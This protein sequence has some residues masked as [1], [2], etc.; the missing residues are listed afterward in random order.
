M[1]DIDELINKL[2]QDTAITKRAPHPFM[3]S[4]QWMGAA[5][6]Y[7]PIALLLFGARN[8][9][10]S[11]LHDF[12]FMAEIISLIGMAIA[13][14]FGAALLSYP[15]LHQKQ[16]VA[17]APVVALALFM[18]VMFLAWRADNPPVPLPVHTYECTRSII[19]I[20]LLPG[21]VLLYMMRK[22][23]STHYLW[24]GS[25]ALLFAFSIGALWE[26]LHE[27]TDSIVHVV[28]WHYLP[29]IGFG[30]V[31]MWLGKKLLKW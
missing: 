7:L 21:A 1:S 17:F 12:W 23:A 15:D 30:I 24:A 16:R 9:L 26:R 8:D 11:K 14:S 27:Q 10:S 3:L 18:A 13:T 22:F 5:V 19:L 25:I 29:M 6:I 28:A 4:A 2:A 31:G 20:S